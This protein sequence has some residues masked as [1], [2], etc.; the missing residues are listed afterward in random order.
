[1]SI[2]FLLGVDYEPDHHNPLDYQTCGRTTVPVHLRISGGKPVIKGSWPWQVLILNEDF[3]PFCGGVVLHERWVL[4]AAHCNRERL[5]V[6]A[7]EHD[8]SYVEGTEQQTAVDKIFVHPHYDAQTVDNDLMLL[9]VAIPFNYSR[10]IQ[11]ICLPD[12]N[13]EL[14]RHTRPIILGWGKRRNLK[15]YTPEILH[16]AEVPLVSKDECTKM[17]QNTYISANMFCAGFENGHVDSCRG[18][19]GGPLIHDRKDGSWAIY[20]VT[21]FGDGCGKRRKYGVYA[22]VLNHLGWIRNVIKHVELLEGR[23][24]RYFTTE[25]NEASEERRRRTNLVC[26]K[27]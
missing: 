8:L 11:P 5:F 10:Y 18:D 21:S 9:K 16:Q 19:S 17:Y 1:M 7:G 27:A 22:N 2:F 4:T 25:A 6:R 15:G 14:P 23:T 3:E 13:E 24:V 12:E 20:G 26:C